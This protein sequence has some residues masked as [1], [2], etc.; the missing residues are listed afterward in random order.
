MKQV[1]I[2]RKKITAKQRKFIE[3]CAKAM[4]KDGKPFHTTKRVLGADIL[5]ANVRHIVQKKDGLNF[6][7]VEQIYIP[8]KELS[9]YKKDLY[10]KIPHIDFAECNHKKSMILLAE[11]KGM[12]AVLD[13]M[14]PYLKKETL[15]KINSPLEK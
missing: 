12:A 5:K 3:D 1:H 6:V 13:Y 4:P 10:Y 9:F 14:K 11:T 8:D 15:E 2:N 7:L